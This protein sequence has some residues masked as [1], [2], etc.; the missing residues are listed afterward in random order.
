MEP[1]RMTKINS[2]IAKFIALH[3]VQVRYHNHCL[4]ALE[5]YWNE[6]G[7]NGAMD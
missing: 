7:E 2:N 6:K 1:K 4:Q 3:G 5:E